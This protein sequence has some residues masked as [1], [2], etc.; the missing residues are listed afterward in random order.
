MKKFICVLLTILT[1]FN[2]LCFP[3]YASE[4]IGVFLYGEYLDFDVPP[5]IIDGRT[6][7]PMRKIF[8]SLG[9]TVKW[10]NKDTKI[11]ATKND[12]T[13]VMYIGSSTMRVNDKIVKL[14]VAPQIV[15]GRTLVPVRAIAESLNTHVIWYDSLNTVIL[16]PYIAYKDSTLAFDFLKDHLLEYGTVYGNYTSI[17]WKE[18]IGTKTEI[19]YYPN[20]DTICFSLYDNN[21]GN[22]T[23]LYLE[24]GKDSAY[25]IHGNSTGNKVN[26]YIDISKHKAN[27]PIS[28]EECKTGK[29]YTTHSVVESARNDINYMLKQ[30]DISLAVNITGVTLNTLGFKNY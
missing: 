1:I 14:D 15:N 22:L 17:Q 11:T 27:Y 16:A 26:G 4:K 28:Y 5:Q 19:M 7:V 18:S 25:Y 30:C 21:T 2:L 12:T 24:R 3:A 9:A 13:I 8:E 6:M 29:G 23:Q 10:D 20:R